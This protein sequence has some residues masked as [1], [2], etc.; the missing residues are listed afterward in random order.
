METILKW[1]ATTIRN[2]LNGYIDSEWKA[3]Q[4]ELQ[5]DAAA[6]QRQRQ[7]VK[8][9]TVEIDKHEAVTEQ[10][11]VIENERIDKAESIEDVL[12]GK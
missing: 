1:I 10:N 12:F 5:R 6:F 4:E 7:I 11:R 3:K 9:E 2:W 8:A